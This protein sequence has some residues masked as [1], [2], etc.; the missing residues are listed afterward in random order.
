MCFF[1]ISQ[2][3]GEFVK[4]F[5]FVLFA[6]FLTSDMDTNRSMIKVILIGDSA[7]GKS[8]LVCQL[9]DQSFDDSKEATVGAAYVSKSF[10]TQ[11]G[12]LELHI[13]DTAGQERFRSI[14]PLYSRG[15]SAA[16]VVFSVDSKDSFDHIPEWIEVLK[17]TC[18][19]NCKIYIVANKIDLGETALVNEAKK[20]SEECG[21]QFFIST[22]K[23]YSSVEKIFQQVAEDLSQYET[24]EPSPLSASSKRNEEGS[25][26]ATCC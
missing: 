25:T 23:E 6:F 26:N 3:V 7:V 2:K 11:N 20:Y 22:A 13:W 18:D 5:H 4:K 12:S 9:I 16:L 15:C 24:F 21:F 8:S 10:S 14:I 17:D 1:T 19:K